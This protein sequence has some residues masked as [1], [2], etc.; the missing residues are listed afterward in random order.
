ML[1][2]LT[3]RDFALVKE[4]HLDFEGGLTV[5]TGESGAGKTILLEALGLVMG[6]RA[7]TTHVRPGAERIEVTAE[8]D[9]SGNAQAIEFL[10]SRGLQDGDVPTQCLLRR[11]VT[12]EGRSRAFINGTPVNLTDLSEL[13]STV[14]DIHA[15][16]EHQQL[17]RRTVQLELLDQYAGLEETRHEVTDVFKVWHAAAAQLDAVTA[18]IAAA[19]DRRELLDYQVSELAELGLAE[20]EY[21][22][23]NAQFRRLARIEET[24]AHIAQSLTVLEGESESGAPEYTRILRILDE[25]DDANPQLDAARELLRSAITHLDEATTELRHYSD[26]LQREPADFARIEARLDL[27]MDLARKHRVRPEALP[28]HALALSRELDAIAVEEGSIDALRATASTAQTRYHTLAKTLSG[29]RRKTARTFEKAVGELMRELGIKGG[30]LE[31]V[32]GDTESETGIDLVDYHVRTNPKLPGGPLKE[33]ASG[34]ERSRVSLAIQVVAAEKARL[35]AL[36]L[37]EADVG[38]GGTTA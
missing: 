26:T 13:T 35:P 1:R 27:V 9:L 36:V 37:D 11:M 25:I 32:F 14:I 18:R 5:L 2:H 10:T 20:G 19:R 22:A 29:K 34:G 21:E 3:V 24:Q 6:D 16:N 38:I 8:F 12:R 23:L 17:L 4:V 15:Q 33:I 7:N 28:A 30:A 31:L